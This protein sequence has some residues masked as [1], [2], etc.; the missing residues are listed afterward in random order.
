MLRVDLFVSPDAHALELAGIQDA[1]FEASQRLPSSRWYHV[2]L[3]AAR[4]GRVP[5]ASGLPLSIEHGIA[6]IADPP[7][8][9]IMIGTYDIPVDPPGPVLAWLRHGAASAIAR[10][11]LEETDLPVQHVILRSGF[12]SPGAGRQAFQRRLG[13]T[14]TEYRERFHT[15]ANNSP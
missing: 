9:L 11:L 12:S 7:D 14:P 8:T 2:R 15:T 4:P 13:L 1:F 3:V 10:R 6:D 5:C